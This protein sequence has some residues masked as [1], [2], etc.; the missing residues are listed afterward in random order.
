MV[1]I[2]RR[3]AAGA[4]PSSPQR[5]AQTLRS[6]QACTGKVTAAEQAMNAELGQLQVRRTAGGVASRLR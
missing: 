6:L 2:L 3:G 1:R 5:P 4:P